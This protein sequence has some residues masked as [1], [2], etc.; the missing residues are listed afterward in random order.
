MRLKDCRELYADHSA[1][2]S[3]KV[4]SLAFA[5]IAIVWVFRVGD[6][7]NSKFPAQLLLVLLLLAIALALDFLHAVAATIAWGVYGRYCEKQCPDEKREFQAPP[8][9]NWPALTF[10]WLKIPA[11]FAAYVLLALFLV[12]RWVPNL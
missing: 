2:A 10:F 5:G 12:S 9:I 6:G 3:E 11:V 7:L 8:V 1:K 4:R